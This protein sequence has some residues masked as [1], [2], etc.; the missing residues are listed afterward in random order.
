MSAET[1][2]LKA[3]EQEYSEARTTLLTSALT[4]EQQKALGEVDK[5]LADLKARKEAEEKRAGAGGGIVSLAS[6]T[7]DEA[8]AAAFTKL[9]PGEKAR[10]WMD[11]REEWQRGL[12]AVDREGTRR[13]MGS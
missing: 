10:L 2:K 5:K 9:L 12:D 11:D 7:D 8:T 13:L 4:T 1:E 3:L 6:A